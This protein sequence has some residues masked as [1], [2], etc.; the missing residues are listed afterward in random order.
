MNKR[1]AAM[2]LPVK[3]LE[4]GENVIAA[5]IKSGTNF[6]TRCGCPNCDNTAWLWVERVYRAVEAELQK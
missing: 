4:A 5:A 3:A 2:K 6:G 1:S